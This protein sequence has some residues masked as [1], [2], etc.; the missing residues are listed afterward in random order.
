MSTFTK[1][2][3]YSMT[4]LN[5]QRLILA[6]SAPALIIAACII[7]TFCN[8]FKQH[9]SELSIG[10][11]C[12][13]LVLS[14]LIY[15]FIIRK[16]TISKLTVLRV[17]T[18]GLF[19]A[20]I[21]LTKQ[22]NTIL[23]FIKTWVAPL[24][25][26]ALV[27]FIIWKFYQVRLINKNKNHF[28]FLIHARLILASVLGN[29]KVANIIASE[30]AMFYY[31]F[32]KKYKNNFLQFTSHKENGIIIVLYTF[33]FICLL[34]TLVM[35][36][37]FALWNTTAAWIFSGLSAYTCL[38]LLAHIRAIYSRPIL[39]TQKQV[40]L[41]N[42][43]LG[44]DVELDISN[45]NNIELSSKDV[46]S[47]SAIS[48]AFLKVI[49]NHNTVIYLKEEVIITKAFGIKKTAKI[50]LANIDESKMFLDSING[51]IK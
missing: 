31:L 29:K 20:S 15:Y 7:I 43:L 26:I 30:I 51:K 45:I 21:V 25:E 47:K 37:V 14:P 38:Q 17:F 9:S 44:G 39:I 27:T 12:D 32:N 5:K 48:M 41:R 2:K 1:D 35:H 28:D 34:E 16:S 46:V 10:I 50:I 24:L 33:L 19:V 11:L 40:I 22:H 18:L 36:F 23:E 49:E 42:G 3:T 6:I 13:L 4:T 8:I